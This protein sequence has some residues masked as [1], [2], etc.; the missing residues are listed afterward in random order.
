MFILLLCFC[1]LGLAAATINVS[2]LSAKTTSAQLQ[3]IFRAFGTLD[4]CYVFPNGS[5][6]GRV[7][8]QRR[9]DA[10]QACRRLPHL[11]CVVVP[12]PRVSEQAVKG[13]P[14]AGLGSAL[15]RGVPPRSMR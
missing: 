6:A 13:M 2:G 12:E 9:G 7:V 3:E 15:E 14:P 1:S 11:N 10:E 4:A 5:G 8:M